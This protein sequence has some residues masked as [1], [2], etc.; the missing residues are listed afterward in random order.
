MAMRSDAT[1]H[2]GGNVPA[3]GGAGPPIGS[4]AASLAF[5]SGVRHAFEL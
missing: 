3:V 2:G 5:G 1:Y 4:A